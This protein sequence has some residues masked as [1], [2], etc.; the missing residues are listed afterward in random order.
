MYSYTNSSRPRS[1]CARSPYPLS[2]V[3]TMSTL[4]YACCWN[5]W[6]AQCTP[7]RHTSRKH[8]TCV[9]R[10]MHPDSSVHANAGPSAIVHSQEGSSCPRVRPMRDVWYTQSSIS[11]N[12]AKAA[13]SALGKCVTSLGPFVRFCGDADCF[14]DCSDAFIELLSHEL[15]LFDASLSSC[16]IVRRSRARFRTDV[17]RLLGVAHAKTFPTH[18]PLSHSPDRLKAPAKNMLTNILQFLHRYAL[19]T[20]PALLLVRGHRATKR[21]PVMHMLCV[22]TLLPYIITNSSLPK[23][24]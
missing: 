22:A 21:L 3:F 12:V 6:F 14:S 19:T 20:T 23:T 13:S 2:G 15:A 7:H 4:A 10:L 8:S 16:F 5:R 18:T 17:R 24:V 9:S 11:S 1:V